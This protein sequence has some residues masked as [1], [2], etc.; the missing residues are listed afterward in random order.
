METNKTKRTWYENYQKT[1]S[2]KTRNKIYQKINEVKETQEGLTT[3]F[4]NS[5]LNEIPHFIGVFPQDYLN[6]ISISKYP[7][8]LIVN[9]DK[10]THDGS[11]WLAV[12]VTI[13]EVR[14][15]DSL[16]IVHHVK[17]KYITKFLVNYRLTHKFYLSPQLQKPSNYTC[18]FYCLF[19]LISCQFLSFNCSLS[20]FSFDYYHNDKIILDLFPK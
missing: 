17:P 9:L 13:K 11:H 10:S 15:F 20:L 12:F 19:F 1:I 8:S 6:R 4:I 14:I 7:F 5:S 18:G 16:S 2:A 3:S